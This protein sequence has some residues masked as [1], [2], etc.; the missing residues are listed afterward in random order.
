[1]RT[2]IIVLLCIILATI[3]LGTYFE[4]NIREDFCSG[5]FKRESFILYEGDELI[6]RTLDGY[7]TELYIMVSP[8]NTA[9]EYTVTNKRT[10]KVQNFYEVYNYNVLIGADDTEYYLANTNQLDGF[11]QIVFGEKGI[12]LKPVVGKNAQLLKEFVQK[13]MKENSIIERDNRFN[14]LLAPEKELEAP[15]LQTLGDSEYTKS[16]RKLER[17]RRVINT[18]ILLKSD[19][20]DVKPDEQKKQELPLMDKITQS[21]SEPESV[22][23]KEHMSEK[24]CYK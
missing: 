17:M 1:M 11:Y 8:M 19:K 21:T 4:K 3:L 12:S 24:V 2:T 22:N 7:D 13:D 6:K 23:F 20:K 5:F 10:K 14:P 16:C 15:S 18:P 9:A